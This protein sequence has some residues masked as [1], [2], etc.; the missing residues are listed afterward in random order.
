MSV[1]PKAI[2]NLLERPHPPRP[3]T[4]PMMEDDSAALE[5]PETSRYQGLSQ[6]KRSAGPPVSEPPP[7]PQPTVGGEVVPVPVPPSVAGGLPPVNSGAL[8]E[9]QPSR[10]ARARMVA[11]VGRM[12]CI[13]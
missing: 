8:A 10:Q 13:E 3:W 7:D 6:G 9:V 4:V 5:S 1:A 12:S 2:W 11:V